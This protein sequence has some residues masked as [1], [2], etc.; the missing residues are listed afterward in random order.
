M[1]WKVV[2]GNWLNVSICKS[3]PS[4]HTYKGEESHTEDKG[5]ESDWVV[6]C[7]LKRPVAPGREHHA[8][9]GIL[10]EVARD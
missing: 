9:T 7:A 10:R 5:D 6:E 1:S 4:D 3:V 8:S 2:Y